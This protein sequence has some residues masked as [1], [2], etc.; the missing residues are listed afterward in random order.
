MRVGNKEESRQAPST[1][2]VLQNLDLNVSA[3]ESN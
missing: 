2:G 3:K 1:Q